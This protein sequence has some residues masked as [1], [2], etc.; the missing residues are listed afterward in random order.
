MVWYI[1]CIRHEF[2]IPYRLQTTEEALQ[3]LVSPNAAFS[4]PMTYL[5]F[6][7][8]LGRG[9]SSF[10]LKKTKSPPPIC[11]DFWKIECNDDLNPLGSILA[12]QARLDS[13]R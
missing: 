9:S 10:F 7:F 2:L 13:L 6:V 4:Y 1:L 12:F 5:S 11:V 3:T 8:A